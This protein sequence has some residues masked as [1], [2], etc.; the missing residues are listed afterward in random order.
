MYPVFMTCAAFAGISASILLFMKAGYL[1]KLLEK[2]GIRKQKVKTNW[3]AFSWESC[4]KKMKCKADVV[5]IGDSIIRGGDFNERFP[6]CRIVNLGCSGDTLAGMIGRVSTVQALSP[7]KIFLMGGINGLTDRNI[8][9]CISLYEDLVQ[10]LQ[11]QE[12]QIKL[13]ILSLLP[14]TAQKAK[15]LCSN[16]TIEEF[17]HPIEMLAQKYGY[18]Y[19]DLHSLYS[20]DGQLDPQLS[21]DG[22]H[23]KPQSYEPWYQA[24]E[25]YIT[26]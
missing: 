11:R 9:C 12:P 7:Q 5:F 25:P 14:I 2:L 17:N 26:E 8:A 18:V 20:T 16:K 22:L 19:I 13:H 4:L 10:A 1:Q 3:T 6:Q 24:I 23:L 15:K 21:V